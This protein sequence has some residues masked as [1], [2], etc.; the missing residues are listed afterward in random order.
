VDKGRFSAAA[1][2]VRAR[3]LAWSAIR[4]SCMVAVRSRATAS[5]PRGCWF[6]AKPTSPTWPGPAGRG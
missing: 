4:R 6:T 1:G 2:P 3:T 5:P